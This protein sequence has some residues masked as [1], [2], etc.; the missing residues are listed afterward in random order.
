MARA[1]RTGADPFGASLLDMMTCSLGAVMLLML[2]KRSAGVIES[3]QLQRDERFRGAVVETL[4]ER[5]E[6]AANWADS[7]LGSLRANG[8][9]SLF[10]IPPAAGDLVLLFDC[11]G[12][13]IDYGDAKISRAVVAAQRVVGTWTGV[14]RVGVVGFADDPDVLRPLESV[15][16]DEDRGLLV[17]DIPGLVEGRL[18]GATDLLGGIETALDLLAEG[19]RPATILLLSDG[20]HEADGMALATPE[21]VARLEPRIRDARER[22]RDITLHAIGLFD[23]WEVGRPMSDAEVL[24]TIRTMATVGEHDLLA[25]VPPDVRALEVVERRTGYSRG[26]L[27]EYVT[28][29]LDKRVD[30]GDDLCRLAAVF[31]GRAISYPVMPVPPRPD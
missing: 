7:A 3:A 5:R 20:R 23:A 10:G 21:L 2:L 19:R 22:G 12:S 14:E 11:S 8:M 6:T 9:G 27:R 28:P 30:L 15:R 16:S 31:G 29:T 13:M 1:R 4:D 25:G 24:A 17:Q 18:G 26:L